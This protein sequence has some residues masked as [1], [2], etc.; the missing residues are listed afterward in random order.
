[1]EDILLCKKLLLKQLFTRKK[2][3]L[4]NSTYL[5]ISLLKNGNKYLFSF[6]SVIYSKDQIA[7]EFGVD[8]SKHTLYRIDH[9]EEPAFPLRRE[10]AEITK[11]HVCSGDLLIL[12]S[13]TLLSADEKLTLNIHMTLTG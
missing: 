12:K 10:K 11:C 9:L 7:K 3:N 13:D 2:M 6:N 4:N 1:M 8:P 5:Q